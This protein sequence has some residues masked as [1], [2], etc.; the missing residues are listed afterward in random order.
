MP[1]HWAKLRV[2]EML[3]ASGLDVT[4]LQPT[5][6]MQ[7]ILAGWPGIVADGVF[8]V[9]YPVETRLSLVDLQDVGAAAARV[10]TE[11]GHEGATYELVGTAPL[12]QIASLSRAMQRCGSRLVGDIW[13]GAMFQ[14][15]FRNIVMAVDN[16][17]KHWTH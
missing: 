1:H 13:I 10:S 14:K 12:S 15:V 16:C 7:N 4:I 8:W 3:L 11:P 2:E 9:P 5:A 6:Y 17:L